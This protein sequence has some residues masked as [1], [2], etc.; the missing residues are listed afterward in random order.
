MDEGAAEGELLLH[1]A[2]QSARQPVF[3]LPK[4]GKLVQPLEALGPFRGL[5]PEQVGVERQVLRDREV[6][7][8]PEALG[9][10]RQNVLGGFGLVGHAEPTY[11]GVA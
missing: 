4:P 1:A 3:E 9:H 7:V 5:H 2:R 6:L 8:Q 10:V 11:H